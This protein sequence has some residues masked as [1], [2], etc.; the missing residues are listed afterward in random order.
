MDRNVTKP[1]G[2]DLENTNAAPYRTRTGNSDGN[3]DI[4]LCCSYVNRVLVLILVVL[5]TETLLHQKTDVVFIVVVAVGV[6]TVIVRVL[7]SSPVELS[8]GI[9]TALLVAS[10]AGFTITRLGCTQLVRTITMVLFLASLRIAE[11]RRTLSSK[12]SERLP[13]RQ[14][15]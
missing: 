6:A 12:C 3:V 5:D 8:V 10:D 1:S 11:G 7:A 2:S 15:D 9:G 4:C 14:R 13:Q